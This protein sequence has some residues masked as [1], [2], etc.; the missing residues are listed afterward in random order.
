[1]PVRCTAAMTMKR[2]AKKTSTD[3]STRSSSFGARS[4]DATSTTAAPE[5]AVHARLAPNA[6]A[7][8]ASKTPGAT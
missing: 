2:L 8:S 3:Q 7:I 5:T 1:M 4:P 6:L